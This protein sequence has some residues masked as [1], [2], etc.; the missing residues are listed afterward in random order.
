MTRAGRA[1]ATWVRASI[2]CVLA[3]ALLAIVGCGGDDDDL[4]DIANGDDIVGTVVGLEIAA[5]AVKVLP[6]ELPV[7]TPLVL[8][9]VALDATGGAA[10]SD[11]PE[12]LEFLASVTWESSDPAVAVVSPIQ[13]TIG[14]ASAIATVE[15]V[16]PG[17]V[18][19]TAAYKGASDSVSLTVTAP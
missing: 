6:D 13:A 9:A 10:T 18:T 4:D 17:E 2:V 15:L 19:I 8:A 12:L 1:A 3:G 14:Q 16:A 5:Q 7:G 11:N